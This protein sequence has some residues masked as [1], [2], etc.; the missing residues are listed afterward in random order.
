MVHALLSPLRL[1]STSSPSGRLWM[2]LRG[3]SGAGSLGCSSLRPSAF[4]SLGPSAP[5]LS[6]ASSDFSSASSASSGS[7]SPSGPSGAARA[8]AAPGLVP[9][10]VRVGD[11]SALRTFS[12]FSASTSLSETICLAKASTSEHSI[13]AVLMTATSSAALAAPAVDLRRQQRQRRPQSGTMRRKSARKATSM[14]APEA[15][16]SASGSAPSAAAASRRAPC[17]AASAPRKPAAAAS[18]AFLRTSP[19]FCPI[20]RPAAPAAGPIVSTRCS[21]R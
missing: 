2:S 16:A 12:S 9:E 11:G 10:R 4:S 7:A 3:S 17:A 15:G 5:S 1:L 6:L 13:E 19:T 21:V 14:I 18:P 8:S 20:S